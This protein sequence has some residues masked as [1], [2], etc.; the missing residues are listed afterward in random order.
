M[1][2]VEILTN[3]NSELDKNLSTKI[4]AEAETKDENSIKK[5]K[6]TK[7]LVTIVLISCYREGH[8][9]A[10]CLPKKKNKSRQ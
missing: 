1:E 2:Q 6:R 10:T 9:T 5:P 3:K 4:A 8:M 7:T